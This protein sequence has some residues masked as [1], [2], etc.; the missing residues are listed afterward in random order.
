MCRGRFVCPPI[1]RIAQFAGQPGNAGKSLYMPTG[2]LLAMLIGSIILHNRGRDW[3]ALF[4]AGWPVA[5][6]V[7]LLLVVIFVSMTTKGRWN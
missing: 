1:S 5:L 3:A 7:V 4:V 2:V 6:I